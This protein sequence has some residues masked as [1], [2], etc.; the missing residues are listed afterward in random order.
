MLEGYSQR[1]KMIVFTARFQAG[2]VGAH[3]IGLDHLLEGIIVED[4]GIEA[5][6]K[7][8]GDDPA[9]TQIPGYDMKSSPE[10]FLSPKMASALLARLDQLVPHARSVPESQDI[11]LSADAVR[12]L[13]KAVALAHEFGADKIKPLH[14]LAAILQEHSSK[15]VRVCSEYG[16]TEEHILEK[17]KKENRSRPTGE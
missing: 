9:I 12:A 7:F 13:H 17:L 14:L 1:A 10:L 8:L 3:A 5:M 2:K 16:I 11:P 4:Q 6:L 15:A